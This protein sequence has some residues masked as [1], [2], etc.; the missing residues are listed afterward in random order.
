MRF[1]LGKEGDVVAVGEPLVELETDKIDLEVSAPQ[2]GVLTS[3]ARK[4][5]EDVKVGEVLGSIDEKAAAK[6]AAPAAPAAEPAR[7]GKDER[8]RGWKAAAGY[9]GSAEGRRRERSQSVAGTGVRRRR[10]GDAPRCRA[11]R[12]RNTGAGSDRS[13]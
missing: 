10:A 13:A 5:G 2:A 9:A 6:S 11:S 1:G 8:Q 7:G 3:I 4:D 12:E